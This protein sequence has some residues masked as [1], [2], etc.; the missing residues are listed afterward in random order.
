MTSYEVSTWLVRVP[1]FRMLRFL[2]PHIPDVPPH[3][4]GRRSHGLHPRVPPRTVRILA[5]ICLT[6]H[7]LLH[8]QEARRG[9]NTG[10]SN[11]WE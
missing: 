11:I 6:W 1:A 10:G 2:V 8:N 5:H 9:S 3:T 7:H 4:V